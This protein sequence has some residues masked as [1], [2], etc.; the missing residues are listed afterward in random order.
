MGALKE[1]KTR[2]PE[3]KLRVAIAGFKQELAKARITMVLKN[4][5]F[6]HF[7]ESNLKNAIRY[8]K[9]KMD[10]YIED[11]SFDKTKFELFGIKLYIYIY[12]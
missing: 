10:K 7:I 8:D 6:A 9:H 5:D 1:M 11:A 12:K 3:L 2:Y 4:A